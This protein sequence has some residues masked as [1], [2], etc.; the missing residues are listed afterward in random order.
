MVDQK[1]FADVL[2]TFIFKYTISTIVI[3]FGMALLLYTLLHFGVSKSLIGK[4]EDE[5]ISRT[6]SEI[7]YEADDIRDQLESVKDHTDLLRNQY[8][9]LFNSY[10]NYNTT[11]LNATFGYH[12]NGVYY[13]TSDNGGSSLY[14]SGKTPLTDY[15]K[16]KAVK[17]EWLDPI[18]KY[19][20][21]TDNMV[22]QSYFNSFDGMNRMY[23]YQDNIAEIFGP[24]I[25]ISDY[26]FYFLADEKYNP[27]RHTVWTPPYYDP[28]GKGWIISCI[29]PV[30]RDDFLEGVVGL[31]VTINHIENHSLYISHLTNTKLFLVDE[32]G[33]IIAMNNDAESFLKLTEI[34]NKII[35]DSNENILK[36]DQ[37]NLH[38][39]SDEE[40][41]DFM[42]TVFTQSVDNVDFGGES[43][44]VEKQLIQET[45]WQLISLTNES[46]VGENIA[47]INKNIIV[48]AIIICITVLIII[49]IIIL[50]YKRKIDSIASNISNPLEEMALNAKYFG[51]DGRTIR[52][53]PVT[54]IEEVDMLNREL[55]IMSKEILSRSQKLV[56]A[57]IENRRAE[58]TIEAYHTEAITDKLTQ[59]YNRRQIDDV[60]N[61]EVTRSKRYRSMFSVILLD[62]DYF[63]EINDK[64]G[65]QIGDEIL[66]GVAKTLKASVRDSDIVARWGGDE[67][68]IVAVET[69]EQDAYH[70][71][72]KIRLSIQDTE[73]FK[74]LKVTT[75]IGVAEF[76]LN[77]DDARD[78]LRKS[79]VALYEAKNVGRN[80]VSA[81]K[82][83]GEN[84][85][86]KSD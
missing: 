47:S 11:N 45:N 37:Y 32:Y 61:S 62:I 40:L 80:H 56:Q 43:F 27:N 65:H 36:P 2:R 44:Y 19:V 12:K 16:K 85:E 55:H 76:N 53:M 86:H 1:K 78:I 39:F 10:E 29:S 69:G 18:M 54:G 50:I 15:A 9:K 35:S 71:A 75:S 60:I 67:F 72:E 25:S 46:Y 7:V 42:I 26:N 28:S 33:L 63:K 4:F 30:Y 17:T 66:K 23:P 3:V 73:Y 21:A 77:K 24:D 82:E 31:D 70:L 49:G 51:V 83:I 57:Q 64:Y 58:Q 74:Q 68:V 6:Q 38:Y 22:V 59:L 48:N 14:Y 81:Y 13:K 8:E 52:R 34:D 84:H 41:Q 79:D 20:V 5:L